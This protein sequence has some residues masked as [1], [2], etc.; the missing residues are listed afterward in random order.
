MRTAPAQPQAQ[1]PHAEA[2]PSRRQ[3]PDPQSEMHEEH[4][5]ATDKMPPPLSRSTTGPSRPFDALTS[6]PGPAILGRH[7]RSVSHNIL[8]STTTFS[9]PPHDQS[10]KYNPLSKPARPVLANSLSTISLPNDPSEAP[11]PHPAR[12]FAPPA[13]ILRNMPASE[14][15]GG[16]FP[17]TG[18]QAFISYGGGTALRGAVRPAMGRGRTPSALGQAQRR[19]VTAPATI[20]EDGTGY[21][22][23]ALGG[24]AYSRRRLGDEREQEHVESVVSGAN[25]TAE[26]PVLSE[27]FNSPVPAQAP[28]VDSPLLPVLIRSSS[29]D[30]LKITSTA[31]GSEEII[32]MKEDMYPAS[33]PKRKIELKAPVQKGEQEEV[34]EVE[35]AAAIKLPSSPAKQVVELDAVETNVAE[36]AILDG[37]AG[38][39]NEVVRDMNATN[40]TNADEVSKT[41]EKVDGTTV[42][43]GDH[44][45]VDKP[46]L[47]VNKDPATSYFDLRPQTQ[48]QTSPHKAPSSHTSPAKVTAPAKETN[49]A[50]RTVPPVA[51]ATTKARANAL[52]APVARKPPVPL[53]PARAARTAG[54]TVPV[55]RKPFKPTSST[56]PAAVAKAAPTNVAKPAPAPAPAVVST[57]ATSTSADA[58]TKSAPAPSATTTKPPIPPNPRTQPTAT[59]K[60]APHVETKPTTK[61]AIPPAAA[62]GKPAQAQAQPR[63]VSGTRKP[64]VAAQLALP[65]AKKEKIKLKAPLPSFRP[66]RTTTTAAKPAHATASLAS[67]TSSSVNGRARVRPENVKLPDTPV[68]AS[69]VPLPPSPHEV[70]LPP[71]PDDKT[72]SIP[73]SASKRSTS[74]PSPLRMLRG[75]AAS[76]INAN[77]DSA[78][79][80]RSPISVAPPRPVSPLLTTSTSTA[81]VEPDLVTLPGAPI[82]DLDALTVRTTKGDLDDRGLP[83]NDPFASVSNRT[84]FSKASTVPALSPDGQMS[85]DEDEANPMD[86]VTFKSRSSHDHKSQAAQS[87]EEPATG[88]LIEFSASTLR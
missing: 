62:A 32:D 23:P 37:Q 42:V 50:R 26:P 24:R 38:E 34:V 48:T 39:N 55:S 43:P 11:Y 10:T 30:D 25:D 60:S 79:T 87:H 40:P 6:G 41:I 59:T 85:D 29:D 83:T 77:G 1:A 63:V 69:E 51:T 58:N 4:D 78:S 81:G 49:A 21:K 73:S 86:G 64:I 16:K 75:R 46:A 28:H 3:S 80:P 12:R 45:I 14:E 88:D 36:K 82:F 9:S 20:S 74:K 22:T 56:V 76:V 70:P 65:V 67:S 5:E 18:D 7:G 68:K 33:P 72:R 35:V 47:L 31:E 17:S 8:P 84:Q 54:A 57:G 19:V 53:A 13:R 52:A 44:V 15:E 27:G 66:T 2:G 71:T 61:P